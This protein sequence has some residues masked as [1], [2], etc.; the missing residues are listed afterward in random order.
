M[1]IISA[2]FLFVCI[3]KYIG[4]IELDIG[5]TFVTIEFKSEVLKLYIK[6]I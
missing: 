4:L 6:K 3:F 5:D 2:F 1:H